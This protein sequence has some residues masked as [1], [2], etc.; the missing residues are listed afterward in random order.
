MNLGLCSVTFDSR[1]F[2]TLEWQSG[3]KWRFWI[4]LVVAYYKEVS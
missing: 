2:C 4:E 1:S 3:C